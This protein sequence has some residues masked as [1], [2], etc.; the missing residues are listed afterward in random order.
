MIGFDVRNGGKIVAELSVGCVTK[1]L[2]ASSTARNRNP[3]SQLSIDKLTRG[4]VEP[5]S[6]VIVWR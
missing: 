3:T 1:I 6:W 4:R 5:R 2:A